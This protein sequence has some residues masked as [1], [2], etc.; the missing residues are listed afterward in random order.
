MNN[1][2]KTGNAETNNNN[3]TKPMEKRLKEEL[4][5]VTVSDNA[6][7]KGEKQV[8]TERAERI[9]DTIEKRVQELLAWENYLKDES[10]RIV[11][12]SKTVEKQIVELNGLNAIK[13]TLL[14]RETNL[15]QR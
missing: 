13:E 12:L 3:A 1:K 15:Q 5:T 14:Q 10:R 4:K 11:D 2:T 6:T 7:G 9:I 8:V